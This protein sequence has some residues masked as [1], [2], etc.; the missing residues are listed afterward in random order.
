MHSAGFT[1]MEKIGK[2][3]PVELSAAVEHLSLKAAMTIIQVKVVTRII[4]IN[5]HLTLLL[6]TIIVCQKLPQRNQ[7]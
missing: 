1:S 3:R 4:V 6:Y 7:H 5:H 2:A